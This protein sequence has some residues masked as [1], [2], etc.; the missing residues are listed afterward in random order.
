MSQSGNGTIINNGIF[1]D[2]RSA[3]NNSPDTN[4]GNGKVRSGN[5]GT[6]IN[7][8]QKHSDRRNNCFSSAPWWLRRNYLD[9]D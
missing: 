8:S 2:P 7:Y 9:Y 6:D 5:C 4:P 1:K 3:E